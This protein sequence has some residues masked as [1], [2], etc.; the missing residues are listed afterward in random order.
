[1]E[2]INSIAAVAVLRMNQ[3]LEKQGKELLAD[4]TLLKEKLEHTD[5]AGFMQVMKGGAGENYR[6]AV[7]CCLEKNTAAQNVLDL[8]IAQLLYPELTTALKQATGFGVTLRNGFLMDGIEV[9]PY[10]DLCAAWRLLTRLLYA[11]RKAEP[12][13]DVPLWADGGLLD[14]LCEMPLPENTNDFFTKQTNAQLTELLQGY[15]VISLLGASEA[16][17]ELQ[18][19][20]CARELGIGTVVCS[21]RELTPKNAEKVIFL[22][23]RRALLTGCILVFTGVGADSLKRI[24][25]TERDFYDF[26]VAPWEKAKLRICLCMADT[27]ASVYR[28]KT[29][30]LFHIKQPKRKTYHALLEEKAAFY[31]YSGRDAIKSM[32]RTEMRDAPS[33][34]V[35]VPPEQMT[36]EQLILPADKKDILLKICNFVWQEERVYEQWNMESRY[37]YGKGAAALF[38]GPPGTGKTM[39]AYCI[40]NQLDML[41]YKVD[42]SQ[43]SDKYIGETEK[44]LKQIF[45][46]AQ[47]YNVVLFFDEA[48]SIFSKRTEIKDSKD[49]HANTEV[50]F[51][52]Q[53]IEEYDGVV[54]LATNHRSNI[55][56]AF[57]R[58]M[59]YVIEFTPPDVQTRK[60]I[61]KSSFSEEIPLE[62]I[63]YD[64]LAEHIELSGGYIKNIVL[65]AAFMAAGCQETLGMKHILSAVCNEYQ[66]L[67]KNMDGGA[68]GEYA[69]LLP[70]E[71]V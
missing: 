35:I 29:S 47:K 66:K 3:V 42:L 17:C 32:L 71:K 15:S 25:M 44:H 52:L 59:K 11:D 41:L 22:S 7:N 5:A 60:D 58:R 49:K 2:L 38:T 67:G 65:N 37:A 18:C 9:P 36:M 24:G 14:F 61:W 54:L 8:A 12:F 16:M 33:G 70:Q 57:M 1:M 31:G 69:H 19:C 68:F 48:D 45:E 55:D 21:L 28:S 40:A 13:F 64:Y 46:Y 62:D 30:V 53:K 34:A 39:A 63:D 20:S 4:F 27:G 43:V 6:T 51:I 23:G 56:E 50:S 10:A 26:C